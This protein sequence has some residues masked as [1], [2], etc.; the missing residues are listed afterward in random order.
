[1]NRIARLKGDDSPP[2]ALL[3]KGPGLSRIKTIT[4]KR[5]IARPVDEADLSTQQPVAL[6][7][8]SSDAGMGRVGGA[9]DQFR[10]PLFIV[11]IHVRQMQNA[12]QMVFL[13]ERNL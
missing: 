10:F 12:E 11:T 6:I 13:I 9:I 4:R 7:V 3:K 2:A 1:M 5:R 8:E